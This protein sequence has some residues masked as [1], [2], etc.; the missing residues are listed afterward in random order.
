MMMNTVLAVALGLTPVNLNGAPHTI[1]VDDSA[2]AQ[3]GRYTQSVDKQGRTHLSG[4]DRRT[5]APYDFTVDNAGN[6]QGTVG[7][8]VVTFNVKGAS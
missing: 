7:A 5:G 8:W 1:R 3:V 4:F 2:L 6:V